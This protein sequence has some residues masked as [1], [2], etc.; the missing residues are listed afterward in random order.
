MTTGRINQ[1]ATLHRAKLLAGWPADCRLPN[2][3]AARLLMDC[4]CPSRRLP[5]RRRTR[6]MHH[7]CHADDHH[8]NC[9][10]CGRETAACVCAGRS[11][12]PVVRSEPVL[13]SAST[14][15][16]VVR[17]S[18]RCPPRQCA[19]ERR[20]CVA[21]RRLPYAAAVSAALVVRRSRAL[22]RREVCL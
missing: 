6:R 11:R 10:R 2:T 18:C 3:F 21:D 22:A 14:A 1:I 8:H 13:C 16:S 17:L 9:V 20:V 7:H 4:C 15:T 5:A 12:V 19:A